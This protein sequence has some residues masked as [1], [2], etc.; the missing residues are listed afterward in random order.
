[1]SRG[2]KCS[3]CSDQNHGQIYALIASGVKLK[4]VLE[5]IPGLSPFA[6]SRHKRNCLGPSPAINGAGDSLESQLAMWQ[7]KALDLYVASGAALDLRGQASAIAA[8]IR[9]LQFQVKNREKLAEQ[10]T[11]DLPSNGSDFSESDALKFRS[12]CDVMIATASSTDYASSFAR[13]AGLQLLV[14]Q[15]PNLLPVLQKLAHDP[16]LLAQVQTLASGGTT[17]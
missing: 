12:Y 6:L 5:Q 4:A 15:N 16:V 13:A 11:R 9:G 7:Q 2:H 1:M 10:T 8:G 14:E 17:A 3:I